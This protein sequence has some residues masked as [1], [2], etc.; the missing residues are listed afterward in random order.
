M[1]DQ[2]FNQSIAQIPPTEL[3]QHLSGNLK[4]LQLIDVREPQ[5]VAIACLKGFDNL[6]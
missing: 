1:P 6:P 3:A 4:E 2:F 5:E